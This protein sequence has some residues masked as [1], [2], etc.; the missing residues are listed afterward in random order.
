MHLFCLTEFVKCHWNW[1][2]LI[3]K[4]TSPWNMWN[5]LIRKFEI[6]G[7][8]NFAV[9][10]FMHFS[11][12]MSVD[13]CILHLTICSSDLDFVC[14]P[15]Y[16]ENYFPELTGR[17]KGSGGTIHQ[18]RTLIFKK[19]YMSIQHSAK[20]QTAVVLYSGVICI[21]NSRDHRKVQSQQWKHLNNMQ[22]L[23]KVNKE[24]NSRVN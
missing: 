9:S 15:C 7:T 22:N 10:A 3:L 12:F 16:W 8:W 21:T 20:F 2:Q 18:R 1:E 23:F 13:E 11:Y 17:V 19:I 14:T 6:V 5:T 24:D 4:P